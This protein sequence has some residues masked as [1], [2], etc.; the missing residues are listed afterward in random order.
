MHA[1]TQIAETPDQIFERTKA[2][3]IQLS[4]PEFRHAVLTVPSSS[5]FLCRPRWV[6][7]NPSS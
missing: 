7:F 3:E 4:R 1:T 6:K 2:R 5:L